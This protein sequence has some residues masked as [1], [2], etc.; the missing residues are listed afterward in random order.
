LPAYSMY[1]GGL[2]SSATASLSFY[3]LPLSPPCLLH[4]HSCTDRSTVTHD[5]PTIL[6]ATSIV[7]CTPSSFCQPV[8]IA[9]FLPFSSPLWLHPLIILPTC[10]QSPCWQR[11]RL[12]AIFLAALAPPP[13]RF[14]NLYPDTLL[15]A[16]SPSCH[17]PRRF[18]SLSCL[19]DILLAMPTSFHQ[20]SSHRQPLTHQLLP[21]YCPHFT[22]PF[23][24]HSLSCWSPPSCHQS[25]LHRSSPS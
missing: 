15:A 22:S 10:T 8:P 12:P 21:S 2:T 17:F 11:R 14:A 3:P 6:S 16:S 23:F 5:R 9:A 18:F 19:L 13:H 7:G 1:P 24:C 20:S 4:I 25:L